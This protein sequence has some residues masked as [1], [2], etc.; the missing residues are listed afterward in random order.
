LLA[1]GARAQTAD[2]PYAMRTEPCPVLNDV[3]ED[4]KADMED[5]RARNEV[6]RVI[7]LKVRDRLDKADLDTVKRF[8]E[9]FTFEEIPVSESD[10]QKGIV[11]ILS[12]FIIIGEETGPWSKEDPSQLGELRVYA[13]VSCYQKADGTHWCWGRYGRG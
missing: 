5:Q 11:R 3:W 6:L 4:M 8:F 10:R 1:S 2:L 9:C 13:R 7:G 12:G